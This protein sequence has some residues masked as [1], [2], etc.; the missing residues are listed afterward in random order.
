MEMTD[1]LFV[2]IQQKATKHE[3]EP[4]NTIYIKKHSL[5]SNQLSESLMVSETTSF[6]L[7]RP[8][9]MRSF[10]Q[11]PLCTGRVV[12]ECVIQSMSQLFTWKHSIPAVLWHTQQTDK[13]QCRLNDFSVELPTFCSFHYFSFLLA[14]SRSKSD[15][16]GGELR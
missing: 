5:F 10:F 4:L 12:P 9:F 1:F 2:N 13:Q 8:L 7:N 3:Y 6:H 11:M 14:I 15:S 16:F